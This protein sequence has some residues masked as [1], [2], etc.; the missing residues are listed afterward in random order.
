MVRIDR[1]II[2][3]YRFKFEQPVEMTS[4]LIHY[5]GEYSVAVGVVL[6][7]L[8]ER[9]YVGVSIADKLIAPVE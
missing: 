3:V 8:A 4:S 6:G 2:F 5:V 7:R 1:H 9:S